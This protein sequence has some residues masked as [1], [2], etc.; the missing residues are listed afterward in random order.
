MTSMEWLRNH[1]NNTYHVKGNGE[2][3]AMGS[4][5]VAANS[6]T[7]LRDGRDFEYR[8]DMTARTAAL[9]F[10]G[11]R[12]VHTFTGLPTDGVVPYAMFGGSNQVLRLLPA[13]KH[14]FL[15]YSRTPGVPMDG[16]FGCVS[17]DRIQGF[18]RALADRTQMPIPLARN[19]YLHYRLAALLPTALAPSRSTAMVVGP[20]SVRV[21]HTGSRGR[22]AAVQAATPFPLAHDPAGQRLAATGGAGG[23]V[24]YFEIAVEKAPAATAVGL[25]LAHAGFVAD[26]KMVGWLKGSVGFHGDDGKVYHGPGGKTELGTM[27]GEGDVAGCG[28]VVGTRDVFFTVNGRLVGV[29]QSGPEVVENCGNDRRL[30]PTISMNG[31]GQVAVNFGA[32]TFRFDPTTAEA[33]LLEAGELSNPVAEEGED[34]AEAAVSDTNIDVFSAQPSTNAASHAAAAANLNNA[35]AGRTGSAAAATRVLANNTTSV[36]KLVIV[37]DAVAKLDSFVTLA[38]GTKLPLCSLAG[39][40]GRVVLREGESWPP[41]NAKVCVRL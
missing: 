40:V 13:P 12:V 24:A 7:A 15:V 26:G 27:F 20:S 37:N 10:D 3:V 32:S 9:V 34:A 17:G 8:V 14:T 29:G 2:V 21:V 5:V 31:P 39:C 38:D 25:G 23:G 36:P 41:S 35:T 19:V 4:T 30:Y 18:S 1:T 28:Y 6:N 33:A 16:L 22:R 11:D